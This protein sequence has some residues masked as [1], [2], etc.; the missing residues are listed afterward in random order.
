M[1]EQLLSADKQRSCETKEFVLPLALRPRERW[2]SRT[3]RPVTPVFFRR[4]EL[5]LLNNLEMTIENFSLA[6]KTVTVKFRETRQDCD[7]LRRISL[8]DVNER[9]G[10]IWIG[11]IGEVLCEMIDFNGQLR[12]Y[13]ALAKDVDVHSLER[14]EQKLPIEHS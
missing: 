2:G 12:F 6:Q 7:G 9:E 1:V 5:R 3:D 14:R 8:V 11:D 13:M 4:G 10:I